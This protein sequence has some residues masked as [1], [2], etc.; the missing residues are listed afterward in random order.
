MRLSCSD[1]LHKSDKTALQKGVNALQE[2]TQ[3][4]FLK[5]G[6]NGLDGN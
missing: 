1:I 4:W 5:L 6:V 2:W 3:K